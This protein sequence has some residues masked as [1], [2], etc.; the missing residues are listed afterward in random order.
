MIFRPT[1]PET[2]RPKNKSRHL[3]VFSS[4]VHFA[5]DEAGIQ[6]DSLEAAR[7]GLGSAAG[8]EQCERGELQEV[9]GMSF[10]GKMFVRC[11]WVSI[12]SFE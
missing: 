6:G 7:S 9:R 3:F 1:D 4:H 2:W 8:R 12:R 11:V 10:A 5:D